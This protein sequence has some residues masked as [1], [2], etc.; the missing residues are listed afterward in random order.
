M[1]YHGEGMYQWDTWYCKRKGTDEVHAFYLQCKRPGSTRTDREA[2]SLGHAVS[3]N[4]LDWQELPPVLPPD[5]PGCP[6]D[7]QS[8]TGSTIER[9]G[10][11]YMYYTIRSSADSAKHQSIGLAMS[12]DL[13]NWTKYEGNPVIEPDGRWYNTRENPA[14]NDLVDCRDLM[15]VKHPDQPGY[16]GV[17]AT[18]IPTDELPQGS[19]FAG[20]YT[21]DMVQWQQTSPVYRS[22]QDRYSIV[23]MPDL[24]ELDGKWYLTILENNAYGNR[25]VLG[26][27]LLTS[28][29]FYAVADNVEGPYA[30]PEDNILMASMGFNGFSCRSVDFHGKKYMLYSMAENEGENNLKWAFGVLGTPKEL[31]VIDGKLRACWAD[32]L[33]QKLSRTLIGPRNLPA[34]LPFRSTHETDGNWQ[35]R[36]GILRGSVQTAWCCYTFDAAGRNFLFSA[37]ITLEHGVAAGLLIR[38]NDGHAGGVALLDFARGQVGFFTVPRFQ[39]VDMRKWA[40]QLGRKYHV[41]V[42]ANREF[43]EVYIDDVLVLQFVCHFTPEGRFGLLVDRGAARFTNISARELVID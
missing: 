27:Q 18:R 37:D 25:E 39:L 30:E 35:E 41:K 6:G 11:Y 34:K 31:K 19:V 32:L 24:F 16:F 22:A 15:V 13:M 43:I 40:L 28:G 1:N 38:Q 42:L 2:D 26:E 5:E 8:W 33:E 10:T 7:M 23:E 4:L 3:T 17:F 36:N 29:T 21:E 9:D 12:T 20:A 14:P